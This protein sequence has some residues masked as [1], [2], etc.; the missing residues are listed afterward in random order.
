MRANDW[1][2]W[3]AGT[4]RE[5]MAAPEFDRYFAVKL[6]RPRAVMMLTQHGL[7]SRHRRDCW[8]YVS[9]N[10]PELSIKQKILRH[11]YEE[12]IKDDYSDQ[13]HLDLVIRQGKAVGMTPDEVLAV[14]PL[15]I[16]RACLYAWAWMTREKS[17][18]EG[19]AALTVTEWSNDDRLLADQ[20]GGHA[21]RSA[22]RWMEDL[23]LKWKDM[24]NYKVHSQADEEHGRMFLADLEK[25]ANGEREAE[26]MQAVRESLDLFRIFRGGVA[27]AMEGIPF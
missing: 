7:F 12:V 2:S 20:G 27:A 15:P 1:Q 14:E 19:L 22:R 11:E 6:N 18:I 25:F 26:A 9:A 10:C 17:W 3:L 8:A 4:V 5:V 23:G 24:P 21:T 16:T 13:G